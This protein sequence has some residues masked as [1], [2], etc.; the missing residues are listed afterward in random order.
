MQGAPPSENEAQVVPTDGTDNS[1]GGTAQVLRVEEESQQ[2]AP[3]LRT[4]RSAAEP[5]GS[6]EGTGDVATAAV[7]AATAT[8]ERQK[9]EEKETRE[10]AVGAGAGETAPEPPPDAAPAAADDKAAAEGAADEGAT[11]NA[12]GAPDAEGAPQPRAGDDAGGGAG[13]AAPELQHQPSATGVAKHRVFTEEELAAYMEQQRQR[14]REKKE[15]AR[16]SKSKR[17]STAAGSSRARGSRGGAGSMRLPPIDANAAQLAQQQFFATAAA[18]DP[19]LAAAAAM[20]PLAHQLA[21][22]GAALPPAGVDAPM[23]P[24]SNLFAP[25]AAPPFNNRLRFPL[26]Q[27]QQQAL[28]QP[29]AFCPQWGVQPPSQPPFMGLPPPCATPPMFNPSAIMRM[30]Q[31]PQQ[32]NEPNSQFVNP[33]QFPNTAQGGMLGLSMQELEVLARLIVLARNE[34]Q[35]QQQQQQQ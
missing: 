2:S 12:P 11:E 15:E 6:R 28:Q 27:Q 4:P 19:S 5:P 31:Q 26:Q 10:E 8:G 34:Q 9:G 3:A 20:Y 23:P 32:I 21:Y 18:A 24:Y 35:Q 29:P 33:A 7:A 13:Q 30:D 25:N 1:Q 14:E 17:N 16:H 22:A